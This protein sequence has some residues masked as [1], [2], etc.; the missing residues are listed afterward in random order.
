[1]APQG[2][3][4]SE[5]SMLFYRT[6]RRLSWVIL[7]VFFRMKVL[8]ADRIPLQGPVV[9]VANHE[10]FLDP[11]VVGVAL[12]GRPPATFLA[13]PWL[14][15]RPIAGG[16]ARHVGAIP[17]YGEGK[18]VTALRESIRVLRQGGTVALFPQGGIARNGISGGAVFMAVKGQAPVLPMRITGAGKALPLKRW[19]PSLFTKITVDVQPPI[20]PTDLHPPGV[21]TSSAVDRGVELLARALMLV[22]ATCAVN[23]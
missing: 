7:K 23:D 6:M 10:S 15:S 8:G 14:Y 18:E 12:I 17:A 1:V 5:V 3:G 22:G 4:V 20:M 13:A 11:F 9:A 2:R 19:W 21:P 16:F